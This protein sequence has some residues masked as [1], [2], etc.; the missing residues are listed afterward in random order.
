MVAAGGGVVRRRQM[1]LVDAE[2]ASMVARGVG[3]GNVTGGARQMKA[4]IKSR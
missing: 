1:K 3:C 4:E 2:K